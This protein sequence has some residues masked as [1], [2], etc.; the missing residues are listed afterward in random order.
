MLYNK[1]DKVR[2][3]NIS[4]GHGDEYNGAVGKVSIGGDEW[5]SVR[6]FCKHNRL[7]EA[8]FLIN[9]LCK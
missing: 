8:V 9:S 4:I 6:G 7:R 3:K 5:V 2:I 1:N